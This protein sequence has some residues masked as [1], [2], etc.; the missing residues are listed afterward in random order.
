MSAERNHRSNEAQQGTVCGRKSDA[1]IAADRAVQQRWT[2]AC[3]L[4]LITLVKGI[5]DIRNGHQ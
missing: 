4:L 3:T 2:T 5:L 1:S